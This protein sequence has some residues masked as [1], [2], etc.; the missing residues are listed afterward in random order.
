MANLQAELKAAQAVIVELRALLDYDTGL[1]L[2][3]RKNERK[4]IVTMLYAKV[5]EIDDYSPYPSGLERA[6][7]LVSQMESTPTTE[8]EG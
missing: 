1:V 6:A 4:R 2:R 3:A 5:R 8:E 7:L